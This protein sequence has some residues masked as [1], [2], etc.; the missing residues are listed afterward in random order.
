[1]GIEKKEWG[2]IISPTGRRPNKAKGERYVH[3]DYPCVPSDESTVL[4]R[5]R[6]AQDELHAFPEVYRLPLANITLPLFDMHIGFN[7]YLST[8]GPDCSHFCYTPVLAE[9]IAFALTAIIQAADSGI[10]QA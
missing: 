7:Q 4:W 9:A 1:M 6:I 10:P 3:G 5:N 2:K 8:G